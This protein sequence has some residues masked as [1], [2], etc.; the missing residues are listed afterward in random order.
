MTEQTIS[1]LS[2]NAKVNEG[3]AEDVLQAC[4]PI[5]SRCERIPKQ[6]SC[7]MVKGLSTAPAKPDATASNASAGEQ[8]SRT[9]I[10]HKQM[11]FQL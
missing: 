8:V 2:V 3:P 4:V 9:L 7:T 11:I 10:V 5:R 1:A 6:V